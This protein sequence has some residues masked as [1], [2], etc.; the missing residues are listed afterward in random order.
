MVNL[1]AQQEKKLKAE[2]PTTAAGKKVKQIK[3]D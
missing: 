1:V 2:N 3:H